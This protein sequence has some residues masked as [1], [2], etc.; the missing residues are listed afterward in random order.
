MTKK[1]SLA[2][3]HPELAAQADG[4]DPTTLTALSNK[5]TKWICVEGHKWLSV[6]ANR[7]RGSGCPSCAQSGFDPNEDGYLYFIEHDD[8]EMLQIG[9]T[10]FP[11]DRLRDHEL[12]GWTYLEIRGRMDGHHTQNLETVMLRSIKKRGAVFANNTDI[13]KF[14]GWTEAWTKASL[15]V[16]SIKQLLD[17]I[18][19]DDGLLIEEGKIRP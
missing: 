1:P 5:R 17:W 16:T 18:Y 7:S 4:W 2:E 14:D 15:P 3:T 9:I 12:L 13:K 6:V 11:K 8:W 19:E 10:N